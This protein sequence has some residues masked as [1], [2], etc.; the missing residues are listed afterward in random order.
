[1]PV[2]Y[3]TS[4]LDLIFTVEWLYI[5]IDVAWLSMRQPP[6]NFNRQINFLV[7]LGSHM[8]VSNS[9]FQTRH[10]CV[11]TYFIYCY[12][13]IFCVH[14]HVLLQVLDFNDNA[15]SIYTFC[16]AFYLKYK[17]GRLMWRDITL[18]NHWHICAN[19]FQSD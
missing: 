15:S 2:R 12:F 18:I 7:C 1:M 5:K 6:T 3:M 16:S 9:N 19:H 10:F 17:G 13:R 11:H 4:Y 14:L 8:L